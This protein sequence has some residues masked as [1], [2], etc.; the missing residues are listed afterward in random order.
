MP[1]QKDAGKAFEYALIT[2]ARDI[3]SDRFV[4]VIVEENAS[5]ASAFASYQLYSE[6]KKLRYLQASTA[7]IN[8]VVRLEPNLVNNLPKKDDIKLSLQTDAAGQQGDVRDI[9]IKKKSNTG[10]S[11][12]LQKT[13]TKRSNTQGF[14]P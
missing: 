7:A 10:R 5:L 13:T 14:L 12:S 3:F 1:T 8:H 2:K 4:E 9:L 11:G 6:S